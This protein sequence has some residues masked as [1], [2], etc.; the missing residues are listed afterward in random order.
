MN[1]PETLSEFQWSSPLGAS[2]TMFIMIGLLWLV[3]GVLSF[4]LHRRG[5]N[6]QYI[7]VSERAD[8]AFF[9]R[10]ASDLLISDPALDK[11]RT[12]MI[13]IIA[14]FLLLAGTAFIF[15]SWFGLREG[16]R[17]TLACLSLSTL[18]AIALWAT[19]LFPYLK[20]GVKL[21][22]ADIPPFIWLPAIFL[23]PATVLGWIGLR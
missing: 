7:F 17:W 22:F 1:R 4:P 20:A 23:I 3:I 8:N 18:L 11:F 14:G 13:A 10:S 9:G 5:A 2:V 21:T 15:V 12:M 16:S 19:A 6:A